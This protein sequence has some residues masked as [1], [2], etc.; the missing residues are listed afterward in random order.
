MNYQS[1]INYT[2][3]A[4]SGWKPAFR[5]PLSITFDSGQRSCITCLW[6]ARRLKSQASLCKIMWCWRKSTT[7]THINDL[8]RHYCDTMKNTTCLCYHLY[9][10]EPRSWD[11]ISPSSFRRLKITSTRSWIKRENNAGQDVTTEFL[12][13]KLKTK[14]VI[15]ISTGPLR[16]IDFWALKFEN[17]IWN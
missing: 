17:E 15:S 14:F 8:D 5:T 9:K 1:L 4:T 6:I 11:E 12:T 7:R 10:N 2:S 13:S 3:S 16:E